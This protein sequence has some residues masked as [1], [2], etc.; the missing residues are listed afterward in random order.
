[1]PILVTLTCD[2]RALLRM[3]RRVYISVVDPDPKLLAGSG[4]GKIV[5]D[6]DSSASGLNF[7]QN[8]SQKLIT[9]D[10]F[11]TKCSIEKI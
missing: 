3:D 5:P 2:L 8:Y 7:K 1:M 10:Y 4:S 9:F 6:P 11:S